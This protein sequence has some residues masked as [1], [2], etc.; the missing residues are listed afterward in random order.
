M[1]ESYSKVLSQLMPRAHRL[2]VGTRVD[3]S[4][5]HHPAFVMYWHSEN[6]FS[7]ITDTAVVQTMQANNCQRLLLPSGARGQTHRHT[8][9]VKH[10]ERVSSETET[11]R[12]RLRMRNGFRAGIHTCEE[13]IHFLLIMEKSVLCSKKQVNKLKIEINK[14]A[15]TNVQQQMC[16]VNTC[17]SIKVH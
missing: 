1:A 4:F 14:S 16:I 12:R 17:N 8:D 9:R 15:L 10:W 13:C 2:R 11:E 3:G 6:A 7:L 5:E